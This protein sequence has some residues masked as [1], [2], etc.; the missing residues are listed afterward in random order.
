MLFLLVPALAS[1]QDKGDQKAGKAKYEQLCVGCHGATG[2]GDGPAA[3]ALN[4]KPRDYTHCKEMAKESDANL[5]KAIKGGGQ[6]IGRSP[7]MPQ[8]GGVLKDV[9]IQNLVAYIRSFCKK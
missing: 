5:F 4:P 9:E 7:L 6:S 3:A 2:K 8:W 1:S